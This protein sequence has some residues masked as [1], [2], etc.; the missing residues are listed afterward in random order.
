MQAAMHCRRWSIIFDTRAIWL[1]VS[2]WNLFAGCVN[3][4]LREIPSTGV[5]AWYKLEARSQR[6]SVQGRIRLRLWLSARE[7]GRHDDDNWQQVTFLFTITILRLIFVLIMTLLGWRFRKK[8]WLVSFIYL[9]TRK[10]SVVSLMFKQLMNT[11][12]Y[13]SSS[14]YA[15]TRT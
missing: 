3:I 8:L 5:E 15:T 14:S 6:S 4:P 7:A 9:N 12:R 13:S 10:K 1:K 11:R 2:D